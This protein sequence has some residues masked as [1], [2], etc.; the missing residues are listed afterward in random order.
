MTDYINYTSNILIFTI[1]VLCLVNQWITVIT[2][3]SNIYLIASIWDYHTAM[4]PIEATELLSWVNKTINSIIG[5]RDNIVTC[6]S[7]SRC[8]A[9]I[10]VVLR[11]PL[12]LRMKFRRQILIVLLV[13]FLLFIKALYLFMSSDGS[14]ISWKIDILKGIKDW[15]DGLVVTKSWGIFAWWLRVLAGCHSWVVVHTFL[16]DWAALVGRLRPFCSIRLLRGVHFLINHCNWYNNSISLVKV[17]FSIHLNIDH[18]LRY[19]IIHFTQ[20]LNLYI[21]LFDRC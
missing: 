17:A 6:S 12:K 8:H 15:V 2:T 14:I 13:R 19:K 5:V 11:G 3:V 7:S 4:V 9:S 10:S 18:F 16:F 20:I 21:M 1:V